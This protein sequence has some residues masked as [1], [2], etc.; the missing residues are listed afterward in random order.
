MAFN[1]QLADRIR[2]TLREKQVAAIEKEMMGGLC[3]MVDE[4]MCVGIIKNMLMAR[5]GPDIYEEVLMKPGCRE[6]DFTK[7]PLKGFVLID[8]YGID[9]DT[10]LEY[11]IQL[12]LEY[13]PR[14]KSSKKKSHRPN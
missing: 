11:W 3:F 6:M 12:C 9:L 14:A 1:V 13:N 5:V 4:K 8:P 2:N 7:R 10:D